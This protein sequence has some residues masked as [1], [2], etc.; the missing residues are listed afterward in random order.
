MM[1]PVLIARAN[2]PCILQL[3]GTEI[4]KLI[5]IFSL[6][7]GSYSSVVQALYNETKQLW[8]IP[9]Q[10][11]TEVQGW[12]VT[13][14]EPMVSGKRLILD[15]FG[16][17]DIDLLLK[18]MPYFEDWGRSLNC[19]EVMA[20]ARPGIRKKLRKDGFHHVCDLIIKPLTGLH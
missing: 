8:V 18:T 9:N 4:E 17:K 10:D 5:G 15:L 12:V 7:Q 19:T 2:V 11:S 13:Y 3:V 20:Y 1:D 14:V 6:E 16:G